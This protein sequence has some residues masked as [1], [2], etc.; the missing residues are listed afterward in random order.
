MRMLDMAHIMLADHFIPL[1]FPVCF[2]EIN[3]PIRAH[4]KKKKNGLCTCFSKALQSKQFQFH[5]F[6]SVCTYLAA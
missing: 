6:C 4:L 5:S 3:Y 2:F 1:S